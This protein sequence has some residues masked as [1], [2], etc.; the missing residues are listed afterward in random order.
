MASMAL[1]LSPGQGRSSPANSRSSPSVTYRFP[2][3]E[4]AVGMAAEAASGEKKETGHT[5]A[6]TAESKALRTGV[7]GD[8]SFFESDAMDER[9][10][11]KKL[12][13]EEPYSGGALDRR[14]LNFPG[15]FR[16]LRDQGMAEEEEDGDEYE[17]ED[18]EEEDEDGDEE[19]DE[20]DD[21]EEDDEEDGDE[22]EDEDEEEGEQRGDR[23]QPGDGMSMF[24]QLSLLHGVDESADG[25]V[26]NAMSWMCKTRSLHS[27]SL[28]SSLSPSGPSV[29][30]LVPAAD[31]R[32]GSLSRQSTMADAAPVPGPPKGLE[33]PNPPPTAVAETDTSLSQ[34]ATQEG[35]PSI[36]AS[37]GSLLPSEFSAG[38]SAFSHASCLPSSFLSVCPP[39]SRVS[40]SASAA[41]VSPTALGLL[42]GLP[43]PWQREGK[44]ESGGPPACPEADGD[45]PEETE[46]AGE[47][48]TVR[49]HC[50]SF[51]VHTGDP[52]MQFFLASGASL[53]RTAP[54]TC[55]GETG[56]VAQRH[57]ED[58]AKRGEAGGVDAAEEIERVDESDESAVDRGAEG[59]QSLKDGSEKERALDRREGDAAEREPGREGRD[60]REEWI[61]QLLETYGDGTAG[62]PP[63]TNASRSSSFPPTSGFPSSASI[64]AAFPGQTLPILPAP[65]NAEGTEAADPAAW[66]DSS[67]DSTWLPLHTGALPS[68]APGLS[69]SPSSS[70]S[71]AADSFLKSSP[72]PSADSAH[73]RDR[74]I[75]SEDSGARE[76]A[77]GERDC[78]SQDKAR[79]AQESFSL[80]EHGALGEGPHVSP[81][82]SACLAEGS[83]VALSASCASEGRSFCTV[84]HASV[85]P[86]DALQSPCRDPEAPERPYTESCGED[87]GLAQAPLMRS[88]ESGETEMR[89]GEEEAIWEAKEAGEGTAEPQRDDAGEEGEAAPGGS[90]AKVWQDWTVTSRLVFGA[91]RL[92]VYRQRVIS[93]TLASEVS[94]SD[95]SKAGGDARGNASSSGHASA[96]QEQDAQSAPL[97][98]AAA[99]ER[100][101]SHRGAES[102]EKDS[103]RGW[104]GPA[105]EGSQG[106]HREA[107]GEADA[108]QREEG[109]KRA[110][111]SYRAFKRLREKV[112]ASFASFFTPA[113]YAHLLRDLG[114]HTDCQLLVRTL[115]NA[116]FNRF[117]RHECEAFVD[118]TTRRLTKA[119]FKRMLEAWS[120]DP[121]RIALAALKQQDAESQPGLFEFFTSYIAGLSP[122]SDFN[123]SFQ[124]ERLF[125]MLDP[126]ETGCIKVAELLSL[127]E[128]EK[129]MDIVYRPLGTEFADCAQQL[130]P[131]F[132]FDIFCFLREEN[133]VL[134]AGVL[135]SLCDALR[136]H[137][138]SQTYHV[139]PIVLSRLFASSKIRTRYHAL[140]PSSSQ[141]SE[142]SVSPETTVSPASSPCETSTKSCSERAP[143]NAR[144][145]ASGR[146]TTKSVVPDSEAQI[147]E[148]QQ[149][150]SASADGAAS[151]R[152]ATSPA[153]SA[154]ESRTAGETQSEADQRSQAQREET[155]ERDAHVNG[156]QTRPVVPVLEREELFRFLFTLEFCSCVWA[157]DAANIRALPP[158]CISS[159]L[160]FVWKLL[161]V[162]GKG[163][164]GAICLELRTTGL[165]PFVDELPEGSVELELLDRLQPAGKSFVT[166][167]EFLQNHTEARVFAMYLLSPTFFSLFEQRERI[168]GVRGRLC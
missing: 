36:G 48:A 161:D 100:P 146:E 123:S 162:D 43:A 128:F 1:S 164:V 79:G 151:P 145:K 42:P 99:E 77:E 154:A 12:L 28:S 62:T 56:I 149:G 116:S 16:T 10:N 67:T 82:E 163:T 114:G 3:L 23:G 98:G 94:L 63:L 83:G 85:E 6:L 150:Q 32:S 90:F 113:T 106:E 131:Q 46:E 141:E 84:A 11:L 60:V 89:I 65:S 17:E 101:D 156:D 122:A 4:T 57:R 95:A 52:R 125:F 45:D 20:D 71:A 22:E 14:L 50:Q 88:G 159:A 54:T 64:A 78:L 143:D 19:E 21:E 76:P 160:A 44:G 59:P 5:R 96:E 136:V 167:E 31:S 73:L 69:L 91:R 25:T 105:K 115:L 124:V 75:G 53:E 102:T 107:E 153:L 47:S 152:P 15:K 134:S 66:R 135:A 118:P 168:P 165:F 86:E 140:A 138:C 126:D 92:A 148:R 70:S 39:P 41:S 38:S 97:R 51:P 27:S 139:S 166:R 137:I 34:L 120:D 108:R 40:F 18:D 127:P 9:P 112:P 93:A 30:P 13:P 26:F 111:I 7:E 29:S 8:G 132:A 155:G 58:S 61:A 104:C 110:V 74:S 2:S 35:D 147:P 121:T 144:D 55:A 130:Q 158:S 81:E 49:P 142:S 68:S 129:F 24:E 109:V 117:V 119:N 37:I 133:C 103:S 72:Q 157:E 33:T 80:G 87:V